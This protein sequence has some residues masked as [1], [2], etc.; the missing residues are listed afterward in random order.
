MKINILNRS[1]T[2]WVELLFLHNN[3]PT[4]GSWC[5]ENQNEN[6][7][8]LRNAYTIL[9]NTVTNNSTILAFHNPHTYF[10]SVRTVPEP[11]LKTQAHT[12]TL[13]LYTLCR[14]AHWTLKIIPS[15][16]YYFYIG[17]RE[18]ELQRGTII[19]TITHS[20]YQTTQS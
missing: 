5:S 14:N 18:K 3:G 17:G 16:G 20:T 2:T 10:L 15:K 7:W 11:T 19:S 1:D 12:P 9:A 8:R 4:D 6:I 13:K